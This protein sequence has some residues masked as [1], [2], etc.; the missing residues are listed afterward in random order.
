CLPGRSQPPAAAYEICAAAPPSTGTGPF[1]SLDDAFVCSD[2]IPVGSNKTRVTGLEND[3]AYQ[4]AVIAIG[5]DGTPSAPSD[6]VVGTPAPTLGFDDIYKMSGGTARAGCA[7]AGAPRD[8]GGAVLVVGAALMAAAAGRRRQAGRRRRRR[9]ARVTRGLALAT[10]CLLGG[11]AAARAA[12][13]GAEPE[14]D[15]GAHGFI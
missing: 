10:A 1:A 4:V 14:H 9:R 8:G 2:L 5:N 13:L 7:M 15:A 6:D 11:A 12:E 3:M